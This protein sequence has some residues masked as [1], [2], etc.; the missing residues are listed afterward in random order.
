MLSSCQTPPLCRV[1]SGTEW[2]R[3]VHDRLS[4]PIEHRYTQ[5]GKEP[6]DPPGGFFDKAVKTEGFVIIVAYILRTALP[7]CLKE[8][9][10][11]ENPS[12]SPMASNLYFLFQPFHVCIYTVQFLRDVDALRTMDAA[13]VA[14]YAV[15]CLTQ[16]RDTPVITYQIGTPR[17]AVILILCTLRN[18]A[19]VQAFVVMEQDSRDIETIRARL[20]PSVFKKAI[21]AGQ[22]HFTD[23]SCK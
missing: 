6:H 17:L 20:Y 18:I 23:I 10:K 3:P 2:H 15:A 14:A 11:N 21:P 8:A 5:F 7:H 13:L 1:R 16:F 12:Y 19:L 4:P 22:K 9:W